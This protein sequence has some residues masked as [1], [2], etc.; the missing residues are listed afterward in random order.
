[1]EMA[2]I[3]LPLALANGE[4]DRFSTLGGAAN[5]AMSIFCSKEPS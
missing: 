1:M 3:H 2:R 4:P 5:G